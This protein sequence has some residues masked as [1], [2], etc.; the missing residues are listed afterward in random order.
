MYFF[1]T[2]NKN[3]KS[4]SD[5]KKLFEISSVMMKRLVKIHLTYIILYFK[6]QIIKKSILYTIYES[7]LAI[8]F[9]LNLISIVMIQSNIEKKNLSSKDMI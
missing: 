5:I 7:L 3:K 1:Y 4:N 2:A 8:A 6:F 9:F